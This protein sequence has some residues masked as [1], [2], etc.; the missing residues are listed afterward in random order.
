M[1]T[2]QQIHEKNFEKGFKGY[3]MDEVDAFLD[4]IVDS[5]DRLSRE[6]KELNSRIEALNTQIES[7]RGMENTMMHTMV[8]VHKAAE[9]ITDS[10]K[11]EAE[12]LYTKAREQADEILSRAKRESEQMLLTARTNSQSI[13]DGYQEQIRQ[14]QDDLLSIKS[15]LEEFK[16]GVHSYTAELLGFVDKIDAPKEVYDLENSLNEE[17]QEEAPEKT[18]YVDQ[19]V[20]GL[21]EKPEQEQQEQPKEQPAQAQPY[22]GPVDVDDDDADEN[23]LVDSDA[24]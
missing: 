23:F 13:V 8:T 7:Y 10:A 9:E 20:N 24:E 11:R 12:E 1:L 5:F 21:Q 15:L 3:D 18:D 19:Y 14:A 2:A 4:E 6:N 16:A 22:Y 17:G